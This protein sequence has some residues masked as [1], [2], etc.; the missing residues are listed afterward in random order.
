MRKILLSLLLVGLMARRMGAGRT[1]QALAMAATVAAPAYLAIQHFYSMNALD[2]LVWALAAYLLVRLIQGDPPRTWI[3]LGVV[4]GLGLQNKVSVLWLGFGLLVGLVATSRRRE[5]LTRGPW[6][7][8]GVAAAIFLPHLLW[9]VAHGWPTLEFIRNATQNKMAEVAPIDFLSG[10]LMTM[11]PALAPLWIAGLLFLLVSRRGASFRPLAW[12]YLAVFMLLMLSGSSRAG[13]LGPA[14]TWLFAAGGALVGP[15]LGGGSRGRRVT[16]G[17]LVLAILLA[18]AVMAPLALPVLPVERYIRYAAA[19]GIGPSTAERKELAE[20]PQFYADMHGWEAKVATI[21]DVYD[22][23]AHEEQH[24]ACVFTFNYGV[25]GAV[26]LLGRERDLPLA[27][28]GHNNYWLWGPGSCSGEV[29]IVVGSTEE[30]LSELFEEVDLGAIVD[31]G[32]CMPYEN[33]QPIWIA[34]GLRLPF[35]ELWPD[36]KHFD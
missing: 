9:Q 34:R 31:C 1:G 8:G 12:I 3:L 15:G 30:W 28:S 17:A 18:G 35:T 26:T 6:L 25:A 36:L 19:L 2:V 10:Q 22:Q 32:L 29:M 11:G 23:L 24:Q 5:L 13:Y 4:L 33:N 27:I 7:A 14:Y 21:A 16:A 20:L